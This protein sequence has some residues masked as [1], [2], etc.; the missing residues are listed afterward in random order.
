MS[1]RT[2]SICSEPI[3]T[4][5]QEQVPRGTFQYLSWR[6]APPARVVVD[7][8]NGTLKLTCPDVLTSPPHKLQKTTTPIK[9]TAQRALFVAEN[10]T[11]S[12]QSE[13]PR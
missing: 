12:E 2:E 5:R 1:P 8:S 11:E 10:E 4:R 13:T 9:L 3:Y 6:Y 7:S